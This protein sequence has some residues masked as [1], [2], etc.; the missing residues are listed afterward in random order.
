MQLLQLV[1]DAG[2][3]RTSV[4]VKRLYFNDFWSDLGQKKLVISLWEPVLALRQNQD[5]LTT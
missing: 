3:P 5:S 2:K 4:I 1:F